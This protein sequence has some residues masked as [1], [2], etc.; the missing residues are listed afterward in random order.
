MSIKRS[1]KEE[2]GHRHPYISPQ[3]TCVN[4]ARKAAVGIVSRELLSDDVFT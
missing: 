3:G 2:K 4:I 1:L